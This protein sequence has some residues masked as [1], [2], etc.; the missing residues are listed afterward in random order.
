MAI[1]AT[2]VRRRKNKIPPLR[3]PLTAEL[4]YKAKLLAI[5]NDL[6]RAALNDL[7]TIGPMII[8]DVA[9]ERNQ[10][11]DAWYSTLAS[12]LLGVADKIAKRLLDGLN[13]VQP[14]GR[15]INA[16]NLTDWRK[17]VRAA[18][19]VDILRG[20]P[21]LAGMLQAWEQ[22]NLAL[23]KSI[24]D[25]II[26]Q[27]R[28]EMVRAFTQGAS[29]K[30]LA[31]I[32][33]DRAGVGRSR[34]ELIARDQIGRLNGQLAEM[35]QRSVGIDEYIWRTSQDERVRPTHRVRDGKTYKWSDPG[36]K[37]GSE[38]RCRCNSEPVFPGL[39]VLR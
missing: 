16:K 34:A 18:Y 38:I 24:P 32:V 7:K 8:A 1:A 14:I 39:Q 35:R 30:D 26:E 13:T 23:I 25:R 31:K 22:E 20:E 6:E 29:M 12:F 19:G 2:M 28:G 3:Y 33:Q 37:P 21:Q 9:A 4:E 15:Q 36:I 27:M 11:V 10:R 5:V 17:Q